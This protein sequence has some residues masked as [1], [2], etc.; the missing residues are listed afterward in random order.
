MRLE[1]IAEVLHL[2]EPNIQMGILVKRDRQFFEEKYQ[3][4]VVFEADGTVR[5]CGALHA[6][7]SESAEIAGI[8]VDPS[9]S[10]L[11]IG[12]KIIRFLVERGRT[13]S[14]RQLFLLTTQTGD[15][16]EN[17]GFHQTKVDCLPAE[18]R[19]AIN[20]ARNSRVYQ[21]DL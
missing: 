18:K 14:F 11:G 5:G 13:C 17:L 7:G 20:P 21:L 15:Y 3:D 10:H 4:F 19:A 8:A 6:Y 12:N 9:F 2:M 1:D 16:F